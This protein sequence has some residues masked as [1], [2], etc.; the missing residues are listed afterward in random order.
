MAVYVL[1]KTVTCQG[2]VNF[3]CHLLSAKGEVNHP[4]LDTKYSKKK[5]NFWHRKRFVMTDFLL[6]MHARVLQKMAQSTALGVLPRQSTQTMTRSF[7]SEADNFVY[8]SH[9]ENKIE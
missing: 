3:S 8:T 4:A 2:K 9:K 7:T 6:K 1:H 5:A